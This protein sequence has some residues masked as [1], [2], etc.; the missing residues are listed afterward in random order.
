MLATSNQNGSF[1]PIWRGYLRIT[2]FLDCLCPFALA[3]AWKMSECGTQVGQIR[4]ICCTD[5]ILTALLSPERR[6]LEV[7]AVADAH[8]W[9]GGLDTLWRMT[10]IAWATPWQFSFAIGATLISA[11]MQLIIPRLLG[12]AIDQTQ[13]LVGD[14]AAASSALMTS[15]LLV[16]AVSFVRGIFTTFQYYYS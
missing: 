8:T 5:P 4:V 13:H 15:A 11:T 12:R 6:P 1:S 14:A 9:R 16:L 3:P 2:I 10:V 7:M